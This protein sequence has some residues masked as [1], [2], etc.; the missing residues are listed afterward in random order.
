MMDSEITFDLSPREKKLL[1]RFATGKTDKEIAGELGDRE[2][3][4]AAQRQRITENFKS[5]TRSSL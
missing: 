1:R 2:A 5:K 4:I 3:R